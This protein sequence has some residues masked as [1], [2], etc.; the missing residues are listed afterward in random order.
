M[1]WK[2]AAGWL[3]RACRAYRPEVCDADEEEVDGPPA[4]EPTCELAMWDVRPHG[5]CVMC[6]SQ[7]MER[8]VVA[9]NTMDASK[10]KD[11]PRDIGR[12][13]P[14]TRVGVR[15]GQR[16]AVLYGQEAVGMWPLAQ[17][18]WWPRPRSVSEP[19]ASAA[20]VQVRC[21]QC[22]EWRAVLIAQADLEV[23]T[24]VTTGRRG[25][26]AGCPDAEWPLEILA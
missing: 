1:H 15:H 6:S 19:V 25:P 8:L 11:R 4:E 13:L 22:S 17:H 26:F 2:Q 9:C 3:L 12:R 5:D 18:R 24:E 7:Q 20:W 16:L 21:E 10:S 23:G 14:V